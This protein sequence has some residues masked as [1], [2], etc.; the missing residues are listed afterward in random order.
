MEKQQKTVVKWRWTYMKPYN[1][2]WTSASSWLVMAAVE[3]CYTDLAMRMKIRNIFY[4]AAVYLN[5]RE[6]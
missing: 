2:S 5:N 1:A 3:H 4:S 6:N